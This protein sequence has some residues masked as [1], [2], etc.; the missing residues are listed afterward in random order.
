ML[1]V[2]NRLG[3]PR[4]TYQNITG[5]RK[6]STTASNSSSPVVIAGATVLSGGLVAVGAAWQFPSFRESAELN[7]P[8]AKYLFNPILG[9][10]NKSIEAV[11]KIKQSNRKVGDVF[12][13]SLKEARK[14]KEKTEAKLED[15]KVTASHDERQ[16]I[17]SKQ[18]IEDESSATGG[19]L[20]ESEVNIPQA[21]SEPVPEMPTLTNDEIQPIKELVTDVE[22]EQIGEKEIQNAPQLLPVTTPSDSLPDK[23]GN[24]LERTPEEV[25]HNIIK[26]EEDV[27]ADTAAILTI[28]DDALSSCA[29]RCLEAIDSNLEASKAIALHTSLLKSAMDEKETSSEEK[30]N[31]WTDV[32]RVLEQKSRLQQEAENLS[33]DARQE[34]SKLGAIISEI[35]RFN[36]SDAKQKIISAEENCN[37]MRKELENACREVN[38]KLSESHVISQYK[39]LIETAKEQFRQELMSVMPDVN[40]ESGWRKL[41]QKLSQDDLNALIAHAHRRVDQLQRE[42]A[43]ERAISVS[44]MEMAVRAAREKWDEQTVIETE[45]KMELLKQESEVEYEKKL[46]EARQTFE[47]EM[48]VQLKRQA[49]A[50]SEHLADMLGIQEK[51]VRKEL[52]ME[53]K[54]KLE[55]QEE[56]FLAQMEKVKE[57]Y[58]D[59]LHEITDKFQ[60][61]LNKALSKVAGIETAIDGRAHIENES[62][63]AQELWLACEALRIAVQYGDDGRPVPLEKE[64]QAISQVDGIESQILEVIKAF[65]E[66]ASDSGVYPE[67][68]IRLAF[69][70]VSKMCRRLSLIN[71]TRNSFFSY[72]LS[73]LKS[74]L[75][76][77]RAQAEP[78]QNLDPKELDTFKIL[79]YAA[80]CLDRGDL[81]QAA[82]FMNQL[83][84][85]SRRIAEGWLKEA[86]LLLE[87]KQTLQVLSS[88]ASASSIAA[89]LEV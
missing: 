55:E 49:A 61:E 27:I 81:E 20:S 33:Q 88:L 39:D 46:E 30:K 70:Q 80:Y 2:R 25:S 13:S 82:R 37:A 21:V 58:E 24:H 19:I 36:N 7:F 38:I 89:N 52:D 14:I 75:I 86:R 16:E 48:R 9:P 40:V 15:E 59:E 71:E 68:A 35:K 56:N 3:W 77:N 43:E 6:L 67:E 5:R 4:R 12:E 57:K 8:P 54:Q 23:D 11:P 53:M 60:F 65:P 1:R 28:L 32:S 83:K 41:S 76:V 85:E 10:L 42:L 26:L 62:R 84:G 29:Q 17:L 78:P 79:S 63:K 69:K 50:H 66:R 18:P 47:R 45:R 31:Q 64:L 34:L 73:Y 51:Q 22:T 87:T 74:L 44:R 72:F